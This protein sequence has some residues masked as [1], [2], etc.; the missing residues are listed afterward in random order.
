MFGYSIRNHIYDGCVVASIVW[1][2]AL[3]SWRYKYR[4]Y[5]MVNYIDLYVGIEYCSFSYAI[6]YREGDN[7]YICNKNNMADAQNLFK[8][9]CAYNY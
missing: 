3:P 1:Q 9:L 5:S 4:E 8:Y 2:N 7:R 6:I